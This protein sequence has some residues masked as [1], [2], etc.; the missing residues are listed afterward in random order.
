MYVI[1]NCLVATKKK[2][3]MWF[4]KLLVIIY[5]KSKKGFKLNDFI[6]ELAVQTHLCL[7]NFV[8]TR[9]SFFL[10]VVYCACNFSIVLECFK[11]KLTKIETPQL[12]ISMSWISHLTLRAWFYVLYINESFS[13]RAISLG[14]WACILKSNG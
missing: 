1:T 2:L 14:N 10:G 5:V 8:N 4:N 6:F 13:Y 3:L 9:F 11:F 12:H 7:V